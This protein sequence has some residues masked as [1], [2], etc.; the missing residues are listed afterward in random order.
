VNDAAT[1]SDDDLRSRPGPPEPDLPVLVGVD[2]PAAAAA[3][4]GVADPAPV[5]AGCFQ[6]RSS[7]STA[8]WYHG[9]F[10]D[11]PLAL[12]APPSFDL[13]EQ[14]HD[15]QHELPKLTVTDTHIHQRL[16]CTYLACW[17]FLAM[18]CSRREW[19]NIWAGGEGSKGGTEV[20]SACHIPS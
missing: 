7:S 17:G 1:F 3:F 9:D 14:Q 19:R 5:P 18:F 20:T 10:F 4:D 6:M 11:R 2:T 16:F 8:R 12:A 15:S 13:H